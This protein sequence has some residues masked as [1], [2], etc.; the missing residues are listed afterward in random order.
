MHS[1]SLYSKTTQSRADWK[2]HSR[3]VSLPISP[4]P[5][6]CTAYDTINAQQIII[7]KNIH[8]EQQGIVEETLKILIMRST[9]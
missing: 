9:N 6:V 5:G 2:R 8:R 7:L 1:K 3:I 4:A